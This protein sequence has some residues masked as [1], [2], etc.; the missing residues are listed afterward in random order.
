MPEILV[1][2][3]CRFSSQIDGRLVQ[4]DTKFH[5]DSMP[6]TLVLFIFH[7]QTWQGF[8]TSSRHGISMA[9]A[10]KMMG[11][12]SD[13]VSF[14]TK[15]PSKGQGKITVTFLT[16]GK[17]NFGLSNN[18]VVSCASVS[19]MIEKFVGIQRAVDDF[20]LN[21]DSWHLYFFPDAIV[22]LMT[23]RYDYIAKTLHDAMDGIG[24]KVLSS[25]TFDTR[26]S[27]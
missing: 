25:L 27:F 21:F 16:G 19:T 24:T 11:F 15:L 18:T 17:W 10:K 3:P 22:A 23:R 26:R 5:D 8:W 20:N 4:I 9:F 12:P 6:F 7:A 1:E 2:I 14:S 13:L